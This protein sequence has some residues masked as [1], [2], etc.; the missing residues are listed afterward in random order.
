MTH[1]TE[2]IALV[3]RH[4]AT[5]KYSY[6][7]ISE[8]VGLSKGTVEYMV[9][10]DYSRQKKRSG[11]KP[12]FNDRAKRRIG[13][14]VTKLRQHGKLITA[15]SVKKEVAIEASKSTYQRELRNRNMKYK[16]VTK[17]LPLTA[18]HKT[19]R[20]S[21]VELWI[22]KEI[23]F[24]TVIFTDEKRF[25]MDSPDNEMSWL[26][27]DANDNSYPNRI[28]RQAGGGGIMVFGL[29][30]YTGILKIWRVNGRQTGDHYLALLRDDV[31]PYLDSVFG[32]KNYVFQQDGARIHTCKKVL[33]FLKDENVEILPWPARSPDLSPIENIWKAMAD[34]VY[35][36]GAHVTLNSLWSAIE[37]SVTTITI[38]T[39]QKLYHSLP[40][41]MTEVM[42]NNGDV[43]KY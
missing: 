7:Q 41:R 8:M 36:F 23:S 20:I 5:G 34:D 17:K 43:I 39:I 11:P 33:K 37:S 15:N 3:K 28:K 1:S 42:R 26:D 12:K 22:S 35:Q 25:R 13:N 16:R 9:K 38:E 2:L 21:M 10:N 19:A 24:K 27:L 4:H 40:K 18:A 6:Q 30:T 32:G 29:I 31:L 14:A